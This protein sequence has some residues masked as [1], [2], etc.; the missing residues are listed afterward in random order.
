[1]VLFALGTKWGSS[2]NTIIISNVEVKC[3]DGTGSDDEESS[4][5]GSGPGIAT[6]LEYDF[7]ADNSEYD[8]KDP[9]KVKE[10]YDLIWADE[11]DGNYE[12]GN[13]DEATGLNL[14]NWAYQL[15][16]GST[17][18]G[19]YGWGNNELQCYTGDAKNVGVNEDLDGDGETE[20][21]LRITAAFEEN[22]YTYAGESA[23]KYTSARLRT[24]TATEPLFDTT[25]GYVEA[26]IS[27]PQTQGAWP[28]FWMLPQSTEIYGGWPVSGEID[29]LETTGTQTNQACS[30]VHWGV[31]AHVYKG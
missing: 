30:T 29:I 17:D 25:Y 1:M 8:F 23:K 31:P 3:Q 10:G 2:E 5:S 27:L 15:G 4:A 21:L 26:R 6:G 9:G 16:D 12:S 24:T 7:T 19:N 18:C 14:N 28:A 13:V 22:G 20:G 11:F